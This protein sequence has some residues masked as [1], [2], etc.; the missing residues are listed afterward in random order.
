MEAHARRESENAIYENQVREC[1]DL[2]WK[3]RDPGCLPLPFTYKNTRTS[4]CSSASTWQ[5]SKFQAAASGRL[6][7]VERLKA[8]VQALDEVFQTD[9]DYEHA[10]YKVQ[11]DRVER[12]IPC[13]RLPGCMPA[14]RPAKQTAALTP[15]LPRLPACLPA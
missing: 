7:E 15:N 4:N 11:T 8:E 3:R 14:C 12:A 13:A 6:E 1:A 5:Q 9:T 2:M 10:S